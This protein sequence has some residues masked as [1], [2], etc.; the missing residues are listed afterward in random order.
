MAGILFVLSGCNQ[1]GPARDN[2][3]AVPERLNREAI[4]NRNSADTK[5]P[6]PTDSDSMNINGSGVD[7]S[8]VKKAEQE[9]NDMNTSVQGLNENVEL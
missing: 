8:D 5:L 7:L 9:I 3:I 2:S 1:Q 6:L 4:T